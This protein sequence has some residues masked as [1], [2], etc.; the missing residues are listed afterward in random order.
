MA[1]FVDAVI[2]NGPNKGRTVGECLA[3]GAPRVT[4]DMICVPSTDA[5][6]GLRAGDRVAADVSG[7]LAQG[8]PTH[9]FLGETDEGVFI[10]PLKNP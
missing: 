8:E 6:R 10:T 5:A 9:F 1:T 7:V 3:F 2:Q 4:P